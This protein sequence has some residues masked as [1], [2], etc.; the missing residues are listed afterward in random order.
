V[1]LSVFDRV[2]KALDVAG[3][4]D[5]EIEISIRV[6]EIA[7]PA[8]STKRVLAKAI[9]VV[10]KEEATEERFVLGIVLE[11]LKEM[12]EAD[13]QDDTYS[14]DNVRKACHLFMSDYGNMG[15][16]HQFN[17]NGKVKILENWISPD[18][19][20]IGNQT[21]IKGTWLMAVRIIDDVL[22]SDIKEGKLTG[23]S[24]GGYAKREPLIATST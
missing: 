17:M 14:A 22:W 11:P 8:E 15:L 21:V 2:L 5:E 18:D 1:S 9:K 13:V 24:I 19:C 16:Q 23:F 7:Q 6:G 10:R 20:L 12:G 3:L 4:G